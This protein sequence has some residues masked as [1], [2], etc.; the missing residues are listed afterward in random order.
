MDDPVQ[1]LR[2][3]Q[4]ELAGYVATASEADLLR[5][6]RC[7]GWTVADVLLHLAQTNEM[8]VASVQGRLSSYVDEVAAQIPQT[9]SIDEWAGAFVEIE[10]TGPGEMRD[11]WL[12]SAG[13]QADA[14]DA[15]APDARVQWVAGDLAA[16]SLA[17]T[18]L[19]ETWIHTVDVAVA[20]GPPPPPTERLWHTARLTWRTVPYALGQAGLAAAGPVAFSLDAP[21]G[22]TW[23]FGE[24]AEAVT[25]IT[26]TALDLCTVA[27]QRGF[28]AGT[29]LRGEG[30][31][32]DDVL[33]LM[34]TFA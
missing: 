26:G 20:F 27:G 18:R 3:Q 17:T 9:G 6:S 32:A 29:S 10:R 5:A 4:D 1:A 21:D 11:R 12:A 19:T 16:R 30:P 34:R 28:A 33:R 15:T 14:F 24:P 8:A 23:T 25:T 2:A 22:S 13:A 31:D 7:D